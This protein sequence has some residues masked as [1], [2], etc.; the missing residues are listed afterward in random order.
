[1]QSA[2]DLEKSNDGD[3]VR[4][5]GLIL[6][7]QRPA[8]ARGITFVTLEDET[9]IANLVLR[10]EI[11]ERFY[12]IARCSPAWIAHGK[13]ERKESVIH[14]VVQRLEDLSARLGDLRIKSRDFR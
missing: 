3:Y 8:T 10:Q 5:G 12:E 9:G 13:L 14:V 11:W 2:A 1:V 4:V 7:R 6:L